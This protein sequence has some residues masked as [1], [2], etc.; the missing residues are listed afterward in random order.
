MRRRRDGG[1]DRDRDGN[2]GRIDSDELRE[3]SLQQVC[4]EDR[5]LYIR[6]VELLQAIEKN[7]GFLESPRLE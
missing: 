7:P 6:V 1:D 2:V 4:G 5:K 3:E